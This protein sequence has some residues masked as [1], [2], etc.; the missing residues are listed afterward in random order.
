MFKHMATRQGMF[1]LA[2]IPNPVPEHMQPN[3]PRD[4]ERQQN[5]EPDQR[6]LTYLR[7]I[8]ALMQLAVF[9]SVT[10]ALIFIVVYNLVS[11]NEKDIPKET[12]VNL[13]RFL[14]SPHGVLLPLVEWKN[15]TQNLTR[16]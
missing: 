11:P 15:Q 3:A 16:L 4:L 8:L 2:Q 9:V 1:A 13:V 14:P 6:T 12:I 5:L 10:I 7:R